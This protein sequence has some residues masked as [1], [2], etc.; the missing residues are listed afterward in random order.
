MLNTLIYIH[1][2]MFIICYFF[3][4]I[5]TCFICTLLLSFAAHAKAAAHIAVKN[6]P[7]SRLSPLLPKENTLIT[8]RGQS[9][10]TFNFDS[11]SGSLPRSSQAPR[12][13]SVPPATDLRKKT[14]KFG[15]GS[16]SA[17][18]SPAGEV[19][20][21]TDEEP[22]SRHF[23]P[24][25]PADVSGSSSH[26]ARLHEAS[27]A[28]TDRLPLRSTPANIHSPHG[29]YPRHDNET[30]FRDRGLQLSHSLTRRNPVPRPH[31]SSSSK[32]TQQPSHG[33]TNRN[34][35]SKSE[36]FIPNC[37]QLQPTAE[38]LPLNYHRTHGMRY[39]LSDNPVTQSG[40]HFDR[41]NSAPHSSAGANYGGA[42]RE[43]RESHA[44]SVE[45]DFLLPPYPEV[46]GEEE[47]VLTIHPGYTDY[48]PQMEAERSALFSK[49]RFESSA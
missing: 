27:G 22:N 37:S 26:N 42:K 25:Q 48:D 21:N 49:S 44:D 1:F 18:S 2:I 8:F 45:E 13:S 33:A 41:L 47:D 4:Y 5:C 9:P 28:D 38:E 12:G 24:V 34:E 36:S 23:L 31:P 19:Y 35:V 6:G 14:P 29:T 11:D 7:A 30:V 20:K 46:D 39:D 15:S 40:R 17:F 3:L 32:F 43:L 16:A 10:N